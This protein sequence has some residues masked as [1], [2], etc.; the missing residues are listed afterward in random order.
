MTCTM[1]VNYTFFT[2]LITIMQIN[3]IGT[4]VIHTHKGGP[5]PEVFE[6]PDKE[7]PWELDK[8]YNLDRVCIS[9]L[10]PILDL[11]A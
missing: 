4:G 11:V 8:Q 10:L 2:Q 7:F 5:D 1:T 3:R 6:E 9:D